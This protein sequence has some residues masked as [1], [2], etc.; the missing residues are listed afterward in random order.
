MEKLESMVLYIKQHQGEQ[1]F[2]SISTPT[3]L[4]DKMAQLINYSNK[5]KNKQPIITKI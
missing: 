4:R 2:P 1:Y 5:Q 3:Q